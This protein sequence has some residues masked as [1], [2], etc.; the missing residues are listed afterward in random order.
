MF[1][2]SIVALVTPFESSGEIDF[3]ALQRLVT[4]H[5]DAG[6]N[7]IV[8]A[9]STGESVN[10]NAGEVAALLDAV[11]GQVAGQVPVLAGT[12][13]ASTERAIAATQL[14]ESLHA[15]AALVV[16]PY[17]NRPPQAGLIAH[18]RAIANSTDL[19]IVLYNV[20]SRTGVDLLPETVQELASH[21]R[22]VAVKEAVA[23]IERSKAILS[24]CNDD[25][26]L[27]SGDDP[28]CVEVME[29]G[30]TGV[31]SVAANVVPAQ[32]QELCAAA[33][34]GDFSRAR[35]LNEELKELFDMLMLESN[36][37]PVKWALH[38]MSLCGSSLR[39][40]LLELSQQHRSALRRSLAK[41]G[42]LGD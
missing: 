27:L 39:L 36:P 35:Q 8:V 30:A 6:T 11:V 2:G 37:I 20:P 26:C 29:L 16:T 17:Y 3:H 33:A 24:F 34:K 38:E 28:T 15:T 40:P 14:A 21:P 42:L 1:K 10:L 41:L 18:F 7:G 4:M 31:I 9:G 22:I 23:T 5:L 13:G 25:F 19:P 32:F 12:G